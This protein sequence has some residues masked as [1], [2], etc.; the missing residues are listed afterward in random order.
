[1]TLRRLIWPYRVST[2]VAALLLFDQAVFAGQFL[3]GSYGSLRT[4]RENATVAGVAVLVA[5]A[6]A[7]LTW[8]PGGGPARPLIA[9]LVLFGLIAVQIAI[10]FARALTIH[11]PL[12]VAIIG[13]SVGLTVSA[14]RYRPADDAEP[15]EAAR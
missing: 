4:H 14:W 5:A 6:C 8:R 15:A 1:V 9:T 13:M 3:G 7:L 2:S 10:G 11:V 12:G